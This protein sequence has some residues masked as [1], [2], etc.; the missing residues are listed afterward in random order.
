MDVVYSNLLY[1]LSIFLFI[2]NKKKSP[3]KN[4][5]LSFIM[6]VSLRLHSSLIHLLICTKNDSNNNLFSV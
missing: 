2:Y 1:F 5:Y 3:N 6:S 4:S